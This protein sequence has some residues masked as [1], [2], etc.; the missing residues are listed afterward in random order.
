M[1]SSFLLNLF[2]TGSMNQLWSALNVVQIVVFMPMFE[3]LKFPSNAVT[4]NQSLIT[5]ATF[6]IIKTEE[7]IDP[8]VIGLGEGSP[9]SPN[10]EE[11]G[12]ESTWILANSSVI[13]WMY[14]LNAVVLVLFLLV[15]V[16]NSK[17]GKFGSLR[18]KLM[19]YF[20]F[21]GPLRLFMETFLDLYMTSLLNVVTKDGS[22]DDSAE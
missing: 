14:S 4:M 7:W 9:F 2:F 6:D 3:R 11:C 10:F 1:G 16:V 12:Y 17:T 19:G 21:N 18:S 13:L 5:V 15:L 22:T 20:V 8:Y